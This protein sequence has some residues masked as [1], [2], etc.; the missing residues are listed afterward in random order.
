MLL[1]L[2]PLLAWQARR[3][4][5]ARGLSFFG[6]V[7]GI[8]AV[9]GLATLSP[10]FEFAGVSQRL[11]EGGMLTWILACCVYLGVSLGETSRA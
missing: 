7:G 5:N 10:E 1:T 9:V 2:F 8:A 4:A 11:I 6:W 3:W